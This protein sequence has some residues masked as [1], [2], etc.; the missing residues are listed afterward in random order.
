MLLVLPAIVKL[1]FK[2]LAVRKTPAYCNWASMMQKRNRPREVIIWKS[3]HV[4]LFKFYSSIRKEF[5]PRIN[6]IYC[7]WLFC[8][9]HE[10]YNCLQ[11]KQS[12]IKLKLF[13]KDN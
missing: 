11:F 2:W 8:T 6:R 9:A 4:F 1:E 3:E 10:H 12:L 5:L 13:T 7:A